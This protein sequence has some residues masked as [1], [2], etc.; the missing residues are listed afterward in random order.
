MIKRLSKRPLD[1]TQ[2]PC[3]FGSALSLNIIL[4]EWPLFIMVD[5]VFNQ[6]PGSSGNGIV[7][8]LLVVNAAAEFEVGIK[9]SI[10][11]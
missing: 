5:Q 3:E 1:Y 8:G 10:E 6:L 2:V 11:K 7:G 4:Y 9:S